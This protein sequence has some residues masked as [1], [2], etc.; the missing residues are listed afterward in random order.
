MILTCTMNPA[1]DIV[2]ELDQY[3][4]H[5]VNR[6]MAQDIQANGKGVNISFV[7]K[8]LGLDSVATGF[9]A[10]FTGR[11]VE[12]ELEKKGIVADFVPVAGITRLNVFTRVYSENGARLAQTSDIYSGMEA[13][14]SKNRM[15]PISERRAYSIV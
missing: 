1:I 6:A 4:P 10:G 15:Y 11:F 14:C 5:V 2:E 3:L 7:L 8:M 12:E 13:F 9:S